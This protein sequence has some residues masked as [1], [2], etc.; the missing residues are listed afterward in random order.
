M[1]GPCLQ[2]EGKDRESGKG[3]LAVL[4]FTLQLCLQF[5]S[6][7]LEKASQGGEKGKRRWVWREKER[8][9]WFL[10]K[11]E[12]EGWRGVERGMR[13]GQ[14]KYVRVQVL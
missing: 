12:V 5:S 9:V 11:A 7:P 4:S 14:G 3:N 10:W 8:R 1:E 6:P 2:G 13:E